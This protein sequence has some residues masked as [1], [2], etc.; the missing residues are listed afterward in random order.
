MNGTTIA[1]LTHA[2][3]GLAIV[4]AVTTLLAMHDITE[5]T[6]IALFTAAITLVSGSA[7]AAVALKVPTA[8][9]APTTTL[10]VTSAPRRAQK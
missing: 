1:V 7:T 9:P 4:A 8:H 10:D 2:I 6:A 5:S 3:M